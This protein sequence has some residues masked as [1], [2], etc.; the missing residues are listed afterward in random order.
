VQ[1][2]VV[3]LH[4]LEIG[5]AKFSVLWQADLSAIGSALRKGDACQQD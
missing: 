5:P 4:M 1:I 2:I 3:H